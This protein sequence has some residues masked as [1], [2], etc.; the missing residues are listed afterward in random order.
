MPRAA[1]QKRKLLYVRQMLLEHTDEE[2]PMSLAQII[3]SLAEA[4][5]AAERKSVYDDIETLKNFG[6][7]IIMQREGGA[8]GYYVASREF[9]LAELK[10]LVDSVQTSRFITH[11]KSYSLIKKLEG[12]ASHHEAKLLQGQ[13]YV[14]NRIKTMNESIYY[15]VDRLHSAI[16]QDRR[17]SF[18]YFDYAVTRERV[19]R[20]NGARYSASP[21]ALTWD[22]ENY[23][24][25]AYDA[26]SD[27]IKHYRVDKMADI[28]LCKERRDG[29]ETF[30]RLDMALYSKKLFSMFAGEVRNVKLRF[31]N[32][33]AGMVIDRFGSDVM[34]TQCDED[35]F[36]A[37][38]DVAVS[39]QFFA[40]V[41]G[42]GEGASI[43]GPE[44]IAAAM[45]DQLDKIRMKY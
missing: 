21:F 9:E 3:D 11:K 18:K 19:F 35:S 40:W 7:D 25:I 29:G 32:R 12:L 43:L 22:D 28:E 13:V 10:L 36:T 44:D 41:F 20:K 6:M 30:S 1:N 45:R 2:H 27:I 38:V 33:L 37:S 31:D 14:A 26:D 24:M 17:I 39:P 5:I 8:T 4:G 16:A 15:N 23:Y 34:I 42:F